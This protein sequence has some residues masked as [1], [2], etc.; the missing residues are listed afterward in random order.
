MI[1]GN[2]D[3]VR[4]WKPRA[5]WTNYHLETGLEWLE[6]S[7]NWPL[8]CSGFSL[9][10][11]QF[12][13]LISPSCNSWMASGSLLILSTINQCPLVV[14]F[15]SMLAKAISIPS[16]LISPHT[17][18]FALIAQHCYPPALTRFSKN[19]S[20]LHPD[21][22]INA[23]DGRIG[24]WIFLGLLNFLSFCLRLRSKGAT[25]GTRDKGGTFSGHET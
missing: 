9:T 12:E 15:L 5:I 22:S 14:S 8:D 21:D 4:S 3:E 16:Q 23:N 13:P 24:F 1:H 25:L 11:G 7:H 17:C 20:P 18:L 19:D 2:Y 6:S 10:P